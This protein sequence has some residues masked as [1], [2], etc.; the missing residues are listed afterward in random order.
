MLPDFCNDVVTVVRAGS[1]ESRG[2]VVPDWGRATRHTLN[3][4]SVQTSTTSMDLEGRTQTVLSGTL[5]APPGAD[6]RATD[7]IE[8][9]DYIGETHCF[10]LG[11]LRHL[12]SISQ[13]AHVSADITEWR[14]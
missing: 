11:E 7:R 9:V 13:V 4:C 3:G 1:R 14:G 10:V 5:I 12:T 8:W 6:L 2:T